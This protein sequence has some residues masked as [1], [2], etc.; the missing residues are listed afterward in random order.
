LTLLKEVRGRVEWSNIPIIIMA[1]GQDPA[2]IVKATK[3]GCDHYIIKPPNEVQ[4]LRKVGEAV[5]EEI[6]VLLKDSVAM[7]RYGLTASTYIELIKAFALEVE[8]I[9][10]MVENKLESGEFASGVQLV[11]QI[12]ESAELLGAE[13][14]SRHF[15]LLP[16]ETQNEEEEKLLSLLP[17]F[18]RELKLLKKSLQSRSS[19]VLQI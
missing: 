6:P 9:I 19:P 8:E 2:L 11:L 5:G 4:V 15:S 1:G 13:R 7:N 17:F 10:H 12:Q 16:K 14:I 18:L 3:L